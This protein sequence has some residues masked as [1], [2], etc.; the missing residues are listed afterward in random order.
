MRLTRRRLNRTLLLRQRLLERTGATVTDLTAHLVGLQGQEPLPP[1]LSLH[2]RLGDFDPYAV[3]RGLEDRALV[4]L[5]T[6]RGTI[7]LLTAEDALALRPW[8]QPARDRMLRHHAAAD[9]DRGRALVHE[10]L[11]D[12]PIGQREL[13]GPT[14]RA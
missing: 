12:G 10:A 6:L 3:T 4:R 5:L 14:E 2:A 9:P 7:H 8:T 11:A 13:P 1:Y